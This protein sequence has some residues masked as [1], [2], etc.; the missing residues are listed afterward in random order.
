MKA[1]GRVLTALAGMAGLATP[2]WAHPSTKVHVHVEDL[3][4]L[5]VI[6]VVIGAMRLVQRVRARF[7][8]D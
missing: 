8:E 4:P 6:T 2:A 3:A 7:P 1:V 5:A